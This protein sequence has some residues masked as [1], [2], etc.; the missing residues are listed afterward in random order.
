[1]ERIRKC[2]EEVMNKG[3]DDLTGEEV[4]TQKDSKGMF[5][6]SS[7]L[8]I[9]NISERK[10]E[11]LREAHNYRFS[12][13]PGSIKMYK[14]LKKNL[15]WPRMRKEIADWWKWEEI[16]MD[17]VVGLP[18]TKSNH[19]T[20]WVI[21][22]RLTKSA[23]F[24]PINE[25]YSLERL[26][27][28]YL[29]EIVT[30]HGVPVSI[31]LDRDPRF[32]SR[33][34]TKFPECLGTTLNM[35]TAYHPQTDGQSE[36]MIQTIEHMLRVGALDFKGNWDDHLPL[37]EFSYNDSY[38]ASIG[39][40]PELVQQTRDAVVLIWKKLEAA[41]DRQRKNADLY[42]KDMNFEIGSLVLLKVSPWKGSVRFGQKGKLSP[43]YIGSFEV[44]KQI[45]KVAYEIA[46]PLQLQHIHNM[47]HVS[48]LKPYIPNSN[49]V[50][51]YEPIEFQS[52]LPY[53]ERLIQILDRKERVLRNKSIP[54]VKVHWRNHRVEES[55]WELESDILDKYPHLFN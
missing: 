20:I 42:W 45:G 11:V 28:I 29:D 17:F 51:E 16:A 26:V 36:R 41:H 49:Q 6:F 37:I 19:D 13:H 44:L 9:P 7:R 24:L 23:H 50:I 35:S 10:N 22:D 39:M 40:P 8:W 27:K 32:N 54:I 18:K 14:D 34:W 55:T 52:D 33:F 38:H 30:K 48:M 5:R 47:F 21:I 46:L 1:M 2:Q 3:L 31:I 4:C 15:W 43:R 12:I 53:V 25:R